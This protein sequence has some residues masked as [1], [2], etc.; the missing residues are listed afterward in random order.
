[1]KLKREHFDPVH[2]F[3]CGQCFRWERI[4][5]DYIGVVDGVLLKVF[6]SMGDYEVVVLAG[7]PRFDLAHYFDEQMPF[8]KMKETLSRKDH[9]LEKAVGYGRGIRLL[10]QPPF[11]TLISY[12][13]SSNN[14]I[15]KIKMAVEALS[16]A[17]GE[18]L[19]MYAGKMY[20]AFPTPEALF[21]VSLEALKVKG[22]G[23]RNKAIYETVHKIVNEGICLKD[24]GKMN[25]GQAK[26][27]LKE[28]YGV[29]DKVA[30]CTLLFAF[31]KKNAFPVDTWVK[32]LLRELYQVEDVNKAYAAFVASYFTEYA[33]YAQQYLFY[34]MRSL[35]R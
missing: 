14:N 4:E 8:S 31:E 18:P 29:G 19:A 9:W 26:V 32:R 22:M 23:Y 15:P 10:N 30:D 11:E 5:N 16:C 13:I 7:E 3:E 20:Y 1:M 17:F 25:D 27:F 12:I 21:E 2:T 24:V 33:G 28:F 35:K 6:E 34:Y